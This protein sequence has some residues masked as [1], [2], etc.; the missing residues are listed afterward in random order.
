ML[1]IATAFLIG[2]KPPQTFNNNTYTS[3]DLKGTWQDDSG[4]TIVITVLDRKA[5][6]TSIVDYDGEVF[7]VLASGPEDGLFHWQ[8]YVPSSDTSFDV[9]IDSVDEGS[10]QSHWSNSNDASGTEG[11][12][13]V[14]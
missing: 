14:D 2:C 6:V 9:W 10:A 8:A 4:A 12:T 1:I 5:F 7:N 11:L 3:Q 13:R